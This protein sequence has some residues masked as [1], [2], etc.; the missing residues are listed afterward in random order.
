[1]DIS[2]GGGEEER[3]RKEKRRFMK[4]RQPQDIKGPR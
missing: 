3:K 2:G 1:V 4:G